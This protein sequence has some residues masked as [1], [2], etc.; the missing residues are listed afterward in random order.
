M[1]QTV[2]IIFTK[3]ATEGAV[4]INKLTVDFNEIEKVKSGR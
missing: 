1:V 3:S 4:D 2:K